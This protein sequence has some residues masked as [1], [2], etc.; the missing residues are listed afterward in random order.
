LLESLQLPVPEREQLER[1]FQ[2]VDW[3]EQ[4]PADFVSRLT[5]WVRLQRAQQLARQWQL[6]YLAP[7]ELR[8][9]V[10]PSV[11]AWVCP[12]HDDQGE[13]L[14]PGLATAWKPELCKFWLDRPAFFSA[15]PRQVPQARLLRQLDSVCAQELVRLRGLDLDSAVLDT[16]AQCDIAVEIGWLDRPDWPASQVL[17]QSAGA[18]AVVSLASSSQVQLLTLQSQ[19]MWRRPGFL[20]KAFQE[21]AGLN[22]S[23][24]LL[25]TSQTSVTLTLDPGQK[26]SS[27]QREHLAEHLNCQ[28]D[29]L[30]DCASIHFLGN[31]IRQMLPQ[32]G[33]ALELFDEHPIHL[34]SQSSSDV[35][36]SLVV[37]EDQA[38]R[39]MIPLHAL[40][41]GGGQESDIFGPT[42]QQLESRAEKSAPGQAHYWWMERA[43]ELVALAPG[44]VYHLPSVE[45]RA[46][47]V[48]RLSAVENSLYALKANSHP[49]ILSRLVGLGFGLECV[50][51]GELERAACAGSRR[52]FT[53]NYVGPE[54]YALAYSHNCWVTLDNVEALRLWPEIFAGR[55]VLLRL[56][57]GAGSG[58]HKHVRTAGDSSKFGISPD[59]WPD[60]KQLLHQHQVQVLGLHSHAGS[61]ITDAEHWVRTAQFL[62]RA[63]DEN[64]PQARVLNLG[65][66]L[67]IP[68]RPGKQRLDFDRLHQSLQA[69]L[70]LHPGRTLWLEPGRYLVA[71]AGVLLARITQIKKKGEKRYLGVEVGMNTLIRPA[72]YGAYHPIVNL[73]RWQQPP[74]WKV[75]VVGPICESGDVLGHDRWMPASEVGDVLLIDNAGAYGASMASQYNL[76]PPAAEYCLG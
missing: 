66:G 40:L 61:G 70:D 13:P 54:E 48:L 75:D 45:V 72:L 76:R 35:S 63:A 27:A 36:L 17:P 18:S 37:H 42:Y 9:G 71:E 41:F 25:A 31:K 24:D 15:D 52:L 7:H 10:P 34:V 68:D 69:F 43:E 22:L 74:T 44:Y 64:F 57:S 62:Y 51:P 21:L 55:E 6:A 39:L 65:G 73:S 5:H 60:L 59:Q 47:E 8:L 38:Q 19:S 33:P 2:A 28:V 26:I 29:L 3:L 23:V 14:M 30:R 20:A 50:S 53:P 12:D 32:L 1:W 16:L 11:P 4:V 56:D 46:R 49:D 67:G 58:H